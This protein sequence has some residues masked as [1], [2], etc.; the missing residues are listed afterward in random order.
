LESLS[1]QGCLNKL[2]KNLEV[3]TCM[4]IR[5]EKQRNFSLRKLNYE[6][7]ALNV[8]DIDMFYVHNAM[9]ARKNTIILR[10]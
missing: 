3:S 4:P 8:V 10:I 2:F 5:L 6:Y 7:T 1:D 9:E